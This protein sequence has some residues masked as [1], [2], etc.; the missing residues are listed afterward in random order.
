M[1]SFRRAAGGFRG[2]VLQVKKRVSCTALP[3]TFISSG[4]TLVEQAWPR[5][6]HF[7]SRRGGARVEL[8]D[9]R[10]MCAARC[11]CHCFRLFSTR[12]PND[13]FV[14]LL[15][16][17]VMRASVETKNTKKI[18]NGLHVLPRRRISK[19]AIPC[20]PNTVMHLHDNTVSN[21]YCGESA[22]LQKGLPSDD[23][24]FC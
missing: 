22:P 18:E 6:A 11:V 20:F 5:T 13:I 12:R 7:T 9:R 19:S 3:Q 10:V 23:E 8:A 15:S 1:P 16:T 4:N 14:E 17:R 2:S 21:A 24:T